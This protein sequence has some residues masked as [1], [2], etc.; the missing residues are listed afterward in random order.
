[1]EKNE[2]GARGIYSRTQGRKYPK[3]EGKNGSTQT[4]KKK[5]QETGS[6]E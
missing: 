2:G 3:K 4:N 1:M 5:K 6:G